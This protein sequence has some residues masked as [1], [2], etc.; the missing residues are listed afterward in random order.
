[1][2]SWHHDRDTCY[3]RRLMV[4]SDVMSPGPTHSFKEEK[5]G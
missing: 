3:K 5:A 4:S 1:M 2:S